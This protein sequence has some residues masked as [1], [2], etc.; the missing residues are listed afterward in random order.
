MTNLGVYA[1]LAASILCSSIAQIFQKR[2]ASDLAQADSSLVLLLFKPNVML[3]ALF[4]G[5]GLLFWLAVLKTL[6]LS[7]AYPLLSISYVLV[8]L[9]AR[10]LFAERIPW[11]RWLGT[12]FIMLGAGLLTGA[13]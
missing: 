7:V 5:V 3:S 12:V 1:L 6:P 11:Q 2:A 4:L 9:L 8:M 13:A 10:C